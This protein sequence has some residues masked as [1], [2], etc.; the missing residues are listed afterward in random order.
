MTDNQA[1]TSNLVD[2]LSALVRG[3][4]ST[5]SFKPDAIPAQVLSDILADAEGAPSWSNTQPYRLAIASGDTRDKISQELCLR[6]DRAIRGQQAGVMGKLR[7]LMTRGALPDGDFKT[8]IEYPRDLMARRNATGRGLYEVLGIG[9]QDIAARNR[10]MRK[11]FEFFG[12][13]TA[14]FVFVHAGLREF[15]ALDAGTSD[16]RHQN[17]RSNHSGFRQPRKGAAA[18]QAFRG[19]RPPERACRRQTP[20]NRRSVSKWWSD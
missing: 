11:N 6:F 14:I 4:R 7:L 1:R 8:N 18:R 3:R 12:A 17:D 13:P 5:R 19:P 15:A 9:R 2:S 10:Q 20:A 16:R